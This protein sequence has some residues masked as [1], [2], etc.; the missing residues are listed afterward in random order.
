VFSSDLYTVQFIVTEH[1][2][3]Y[4]A[5]RHTLLLILKLALEMVNET[6]YNF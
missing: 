1:D 2:L 3:K 4:N 6:V 5:H